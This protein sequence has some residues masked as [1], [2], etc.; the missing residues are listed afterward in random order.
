MV[1][2]FWRHCNTDLGAILVSL[3]HTG[4][5]SVA[6]TGGP[7]RLYSLAPGALAPSTTT[8]EV[9]PEKEA[10][11]NEGRPQKEERPRRRDDR[12]GRG[13]GDEGAQKG[14]LGVRRSRFGLVGR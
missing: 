5:D 8:E 6:D 1:R 13:A 9:T 4:A 7:R 3:R 11:T 2:S 10:T 14:A 12:G